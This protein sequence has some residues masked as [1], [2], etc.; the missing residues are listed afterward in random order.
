[1]LNFIKDLWQDPNEH[2]T[3]IVVDA[4]G[5]GVPRQYQVRPK[6]FL[7]K[8]ALGIGGGF[9]GLFLLFMILPVRDWVL[10]SV[11]PS[12]SPMKTSADRIAALQDSLEV[13]QLYILKLRQALIGTDS[14]FAKQKP[15]AT[16]VK[17][18]TTKTSKSS[19][20]FWVP[21]TRKQKIEPKSES[22]KPREGL[23]CA[24]QCG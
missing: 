24:Y 11:S 17:N 10:G 12:I 18:D 22:H 6:P 13:Q 8:A 5:M 15:K 20:F 19:S 23:S 14:L 7:M 16:E 4:E 2:L 3:V 21:D 1:M 9:V